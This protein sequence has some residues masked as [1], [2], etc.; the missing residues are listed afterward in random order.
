M[1]REEDVASGKDEH[2]NDVEI[3]DRPN[4][5]DSELDR[6]QETTP[7]F[8]PC[9]ETGD[10]DSVD[11]EAQIS[12]RPVVTNIVSIGDNNV[13][14]ICVQSSDQIPAPGV[15]PLVREVFIKMCEIVNLLH[16]LRDYGKWL[17]F[18]DALNRLHQKYD[19]HPEIKCFLLLEESVTLTYSENFKAAK[20]KAMESFN[21]VHAIKI[22]GALQDVL[23][24]LAN[25]ALASIYRRLPK[26]KLAKAF[27]CLQNA[28][29]SGERLKRIGN[30]TIPDFV[31]ALLDYEQARFH[32]EF[33]AVNSRNKTCCNKES[34]KFLGLC[35]DRCR[36]LS[37]KHHKQ[38]VRQAEKHLEKYEHIHSHAEGSPVAARVKYLMT[39]SELCF[40]KTDYTGAKD[41]AC[42]ALENA[43]KYGLELEI[44]PAQNHLDHI[45]RCCPSTSAQDKLQRV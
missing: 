33:A 38:C 3:Q 13:L 26:Q 23:T 9:V 7:D 15:H 22:D 11:E 40:L 24:A 44:V 27:Q 37:D 17:E 14:N 34:R 4:S 30:L 25:I 45:S 18:G 10:R 36:E 21:N 41:Y 2:Q 39:R 16:P 31:L 29:W 43:N 28:M 6:N 8:R 12:E 42:Q 32:M 1:D 19:S 35:I 5:N 20:K